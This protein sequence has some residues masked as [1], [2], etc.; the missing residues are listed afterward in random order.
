M[1]GR[2]RG[3]ERKAENE[4]REEQ[5][6]AWGWGVQQRQRCRVPQRRGD[7]RGSGHQCGS[8]ILGLEGRHPCWPLTVSIRAPR[9]RRQIH[10]WG[11]PLT[12]RCPGRWPSPPNAQDAQGAACLAFPPFQYPSIH[13]LSGRWVKEGAPRG[14]DGIVLF[15][16]LGV[17]CFVLEN[18]S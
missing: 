10:L 17:V 4:T 6:K 13:E 8:G 15:Y 2:E 9:T 1:G 5:L 12:L 14:G 11:P 3:C 16:Y 7:W 18:T